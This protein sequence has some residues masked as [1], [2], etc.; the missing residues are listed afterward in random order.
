[1]KVVDC[2]HCQCCSQLL[3]LNA[4]AAETKKKQH[5][6]DKIR[7]V[8]KFETSLTFTLDFSQS[9]AMIIFRRHAVESC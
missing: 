4:C 7:N 5:S 6:P 3:Q 8:G 2:V 1:M 9:L